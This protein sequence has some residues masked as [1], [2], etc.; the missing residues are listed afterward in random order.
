MSHTISSGS[1][2]ARNAAPVH[3]TYQSP[4]L[5]H[6]KS[7]GFSVH[8]YE[9]GMS[10]GVR[11][12][13]RD[14]GSSSSRT[15]S[16]TGSRGGGSGTV[17]TLASTAVISKRARNSLRNRLDR[18]THTDQENSSSLQ[19]AIDNGKYFQDLSFDLVQEFVSN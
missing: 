10:I 12:S 4:Q 2:I 7:G 9:A 1:G 6:Q 5:Q 11:S 8:G 3:V 16:R 17:S 14:S 18:N 13:S 15:T 19:K